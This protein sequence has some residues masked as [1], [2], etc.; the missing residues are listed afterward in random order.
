LEPDARAA[1]SFG[2][3]FGEVERRGAAGVIVQQS[4]KLGLQLRIVAPLQIRGLDFFNRRHQDSWNV[5]PA[6]WSEVSAGV[7]LRSHTRSAALAASRKSII[8]MWS[9][10]PGDDSMREQ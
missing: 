7:G 10:I 8:F 6:V 1:Q 4:G 5:A 3:V 9:F 2:Q